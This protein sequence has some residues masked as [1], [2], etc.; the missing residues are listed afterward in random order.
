MQTQEIERIL[1]K[2]PYVRKHYGQY[3][4]SFINNEH[5]LINLIINNK[6]DLDSLNGLLE[7]LDTLPDIAKL[8]K[9]S[10]SPQDFF[11]IMS[12]FKVASL[13]IDKVDELMIISSEKSS[14][15]FKIEIS[16]KTITIEVK[17]IEDKRETRK[18]NVKYIPDPALLNFEWTDEQTIYNHIKKSIIEKKQYYLTI[19]H[20]I[21]FDCESRGSATSIMESDFENVLYAKKDKAVF[22]PTYNITGKH[23]GLGSSKSAY[24]GVFFKKDRKENYSCLSGVAAIFADYITRDIKTNS[25]INKEYRTV[26]FRNPNADLTIEDDILSSLGMKIHE[27]TI[28]LK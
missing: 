4:T 1:Q 20:I 17:R 9:K 26:F 25:L 16:G 18:G 13:L 22:K 15:D 3:I 19:P 7:K 10:R 28:R 8:V 14:P 5:P 27:I 11:N 2:Y 23:I 24:E 21:I 12:E 6:R